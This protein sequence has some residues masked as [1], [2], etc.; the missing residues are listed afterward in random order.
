MVQIV[1][2]GSIN[3]LGLVVPDAIIQIVPPTPTIAGVPSNV[4][5]IVGV[6]SWGPVGVAVTAGGNDQA[7]AA[8][9][10]VTNRK[11]DLATAVAVGVQQACQNYKLVRATDGT[12]TAATGSYASS[13]TY[14]TVTVSGTVTVGDTISITA[15]PT[16]GAPVTFAYTT[17]AGD[18]TS[19]MAAGLLAAFQGSAGPAAGLG[20]SVST[21]ALSVYFVSGAWSYSQHVSGSA[22]ETIT[23]S[24]GSGSVN[25]LT[26]TALYTGIV[27][28]TLQPSLQPGTAAG[29]TK[30]VLAR[31][32][33]ISEVF[34]NILGAGNA[35][36]QN[37]ANAV[38]QGISSVRGPSNLFMATAGTGAASPPG[39][40]T[41]IAVSGGTDGAGTL[42]APVADSVLLGTDTAPRKGLYALRSQGC[43][44]VTLADHATSTQWTNLVAYGLGEGSFL[45]SSTPLG[46]TLTNAQTELATAG[47][48]F[49]AL[50][51]L[52]GDWIWWYDTTNSI[53]R[54]IAPATFW[55][56]LRAN[57]SPPNSALNKQ[58]FGVVG[59]QM[60]LAGGT[61]SDAQL[62][63]LFQA[64]LDILTNPAPGGTYWTTR[65]G[66]NTSSNAAVNGENY[67]TMT[68]WLALSIASWAGVNVGLLQTPTQRLQAKAVL[69]DFFNAQWQLGYIG[70][71]DFA[72]GQGSPPWSVAIN[73]QTTPASLA[74]QGYEIAAVMVQY[75][76][77]IRFFIVN[78]TGGKPCRS[79]CSRPHPRQPP[80]AQY[81]DRSS[82]RWLAASMVFQSVK[83][84]RFRSS[85]AVC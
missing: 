37:L 35:F 29:S 11:S 54:W 32:G 78:L 63:T 61:W 38:N 49:Y 39:T 50:K 80:S 16:I 40:S 85:L 14:E 10:P 68:N 4:C 5:G 57:L 62:Q 71:A 41:V 76:A 51:V 22:T 12:D 25:K 47:V 26:L 17:K 52:F 34:D 28:N 60:T 72:F 46:D 7:V 56:P 3:V 2:Q 84:Y 1:Q 82:R 66:I 18:T 74:A 64:R 9:G 30:L 15:T 48:D 6:A 27:G 59:S 31:P 73:D 33:Y 42:L 69:D 43:F 75:L 23:L 13:E 19:T 53:Q 36:W 79:P 45:A 44:V 70:N 81:K 24:T 21:N 55:A 20:A 58:I 67:T 77:V 65:A 83:T 8:F